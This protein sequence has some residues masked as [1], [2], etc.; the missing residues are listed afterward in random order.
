MYSREIESVLAEYLN[1]PKAEYAVMIDGEWGSG[2]T[3]FLTHSLIR[4]MET[5]DDGKAKRR[6]CAYVSLYG[7]KSIEEVSKEIVFQCFGR[8][9]KKKTEAAD[10]VLETASNII[11]ASLGAVN[12]DLSKVK[13]TLSKI[14]INN[15]IVCFDDLERCCVPINEVLGYINRLVEHNKCKIIILA[16]ESEIGKIT[17]NQRLE[18]KYQVILSGRQLINDEKKV[19]GQE[20]EQGIDIKSLQEGVKKLF[21]EDIL[22]KTIREKVIGLTIKYEPQMEVVFDEIIKEYQQNYREYLLKNKTD[23]LKYFSDEGCCNL[24]TLISALGSVHKVYDKMLANKIDTVEYFDQIMKEFLEYIVK[25]TIYYRNGGKI[26]D[27]GLTAP[28]GYI[29]VSKKAYIT[30][31]GF[32]FLEY[33]CTTLNFDEEEF[34]RVVSALRQ[35]YKEKDNKQKEYES[36]AGEAYIKL[37]HWRELEDDEVNGLITQLRQEVEQ[38]KYYFSDYQRIIAQ[39]MDLSYYKFNIGD[40]D[41]LIDAMN[42]NIEKSEV[43]VDIERYSFS[44]EDA[45]DLRKQYD[46][47]V[48]RLTLK[49]GTINQIIKSSELAIHLKSENWTEELLGYC[50]DHYDDFIMRCGFIDLLDINDVLE[51]IQKA[52]PK[53]IYV[54]KDVF[55]EVYKGSNINQFFVNDTKTIKIFRDEML[56]IVFSGI[57][58]P[59]AQKALVEYLDDII[60]RLEKEVYTYRV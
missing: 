29:Q 10:A 39:L 27:L 49:A 22:Y 9:N 19:N 1:D 60:K 38:D 42:R 11:T 44:F 7:A 15:W 48:G 18:E 34:V 36:K 4:I 31:R 28:M 17:L 32:K 8:K 26:Q 3:F 13:E 41:T 25:I 50:Q 43:V 14:D 2:K 30:V 56:K 57:N 5:I 58:K 52:S 53:D 6:K 20:K 21:D 55:E 45:P 33:Y 40:M 23:I 59:L 51:K 16:N 46:E 24:R 35:E 12:I 47:Y 54:I 37:D